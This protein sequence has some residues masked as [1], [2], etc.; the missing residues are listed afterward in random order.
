MVLVLELSAETSEGLAVIPECDDPTFWKVNPLVFVPV[1]LKPVYGL[2]TVTSTCPAA[3]LGVV[4]VMVVLF[5]T[6]TEVAE[7]VPNL[8][9][10][11][12]VKLAPVI[13]TFEPPMASPPAGDIVDTTGESA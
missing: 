9:V 5:T 7:S 8:T 3:W 2:V 10:D 6:W 12:S 13:V 4:Q 11:P 1:R